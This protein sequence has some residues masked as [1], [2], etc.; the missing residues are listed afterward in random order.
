MTVHTFNEWSPLK[1]VIV[2]TASFAN[3]PKND[4]VFAK[5]KHK[6]TWTETP[7]PQGPVPQ[8]I[9]EQTNEDLDNLASVLTMLGVEVVRPDAFDFQKYDGMYNYCPRDR[10]LIYGST[11]V[12]TAMLYP[13]RDMEAQC[14]QHIFQQS[15]NTLVMPRNQGMILDAANVCRLGDK[16][17][18][19]KSPSGNVPAY[20]WLCEQFP[21]VTIE[22]C[23]FYSGVHID[24]TIVPLREGIVMLNASRVGFDTVPRVFD[25][26]HKVWVNEVVAQDFYQYPYASKWI[27]M[28]VLVVDDRTV[29]CDSAQTSLHKR[30][31]SYGFEVVPLTLRHSR[32]LG[33][34]FHCVTLDLIRQ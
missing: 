14:Y 2:G 4:P 20:Q 12:D 26:W 33:G 34:G 23:D 3:W 21:S 27:A 8:W 9:I 5:E 13:C 30:L 24:S 16:M 31:K 29:I 6:T 1:K 11:I 25:G 19:L 15:L 32:T 18:F 17:L 10:F 28:N 7:V 22:L